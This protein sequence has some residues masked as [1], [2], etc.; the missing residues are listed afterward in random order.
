MSSFDPKWAG[1]PGKTDGPLHDDPLDLIQEVLY[2]S[3]DRVFASGE[4]GPLGL[5]L[6]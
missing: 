5:H 2:Q 4:L 3:C 1:G 6:I